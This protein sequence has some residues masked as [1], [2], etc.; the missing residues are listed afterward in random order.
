MADT[1]FESAMAP[2]GTRNRRA[3]HRSFSVPDDATGP[4]TPASPASE[5]FFEAPSICKLFST[6]K[7]A[8]LLDLRDLAPEASR[9]PHRMPRSG[10]FRPDLWGP[11]A[12]GGAF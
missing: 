4:F 7:P 8:P 11:G 3:N 2:V 1:L 10:R 12:K 9:T 6:R 5:S